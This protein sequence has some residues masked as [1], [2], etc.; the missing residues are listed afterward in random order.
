MTIRV[1]GQVIVIAAA[2][3]ALSGCAP[4]PATPAGPL[5]DPTPA[6]VVVTAS[7]GGIALSIGLS[8]REVTGGETV[9]IAVG[10]TNVGIDDATYESG[11]CGPT[12]AITVSGPPIA[13]PRFNTND[14][15]VDTDGAPILALARWSALAMSGPDLDTVRKPEWPDDAAFGC[16]ANL[17]FDQLGPAQHLEDTWTWTARNGFGVPAAP[18]EYVV[19][20]VFPLVGRGTV[21]PT[22][23]EVR[24]GFPGVAVEAPLTVLPARD[25]LPALTA[26]EAIMAAIADPE[27]KAWANRRLTRETMEGA[28][29]RLVDG[30]WRWRIQYPGGAATIDIDPTD[31]TILARHF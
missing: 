11:G 5:P 19:R 4:A 26:D 25:P 20:Y 18:G 28:S 22:M 9:R 15:P 14:P 12:A 31:G 8:E 2:C 3:A 6:G 16:P 21:D 27:V 23:D 24:A 1:G 13:E 10:A 17:A 29:I 7:S 30:A